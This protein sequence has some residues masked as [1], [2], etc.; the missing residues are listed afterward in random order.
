M[1]KL[2]NLY[3]RN[4]G[5]YNEDNVNFD[6]QVTYLVGPNGAGK[7]TAGLNGIWF[8]MQGVAQRKGNS[9]VPLM[10]ERFR[11]IGKSGESAEGSIT[12]RDES[13]N[14]DIK[15]H[16]KITKDETSLEI[17][18]EDEKN[19]PEPL[20]QKWLNSLFN[21]FLVNPQRF[22]DLDS[23]QQAEALGIDTDKFDEKISKLKTEHR[24]INRDIKKYEKE[25]TEKPQVEQRV[26]IKEL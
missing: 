4:F 6:D 3:L 13:Y 26:D 8:V 16:R 1:K 12:I 19:D 10:G 2:K 18:P 11:F 7:T 17:W 20:N 9:A 21:I 14:M 25:I 22:I 15:V 23:K 5:A 24:D